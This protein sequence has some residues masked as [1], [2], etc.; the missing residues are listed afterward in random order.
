MRSCCVVLLSFVAACS[1]EAGPEGPQ[2]PQGPQGPEGQV[3]SAGRGGLTYGWAD[4][5]G[6]VVPG[7]I[8]PANAEGTSPQYIDPQTG[9]VWRA[10]TETGSL[11]G[12]YGLKLWQAT[13]CTGTPYYA[14][15]LMENGTL[16]VVPPRVVFSVGSEFRVR[17]DDVTF[18]GL[19]PSWGSSGE[20]GSCLTNVDPVFAFTAAETSV[21]TKPTLTITAP[22]HPVL[23]T[24]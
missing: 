23:V 14:G 13:D 17:N 7:V 19:P 4:A 11:S 1:G 20:P 3:G 15:L 6:T 10:G 18:S 24:L 22:L 9:Y 5:T 21:V 8:G 12:E 2:G 16:R